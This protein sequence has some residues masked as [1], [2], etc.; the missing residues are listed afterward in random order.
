MKKILIVLSLMLVSLMSFSQPKVSYTE[1]ELGKYRWGSFT[2]T[3]R[4]V[5]FDFDSLKQ[6]DTL[7]YITFQAAG[8]QYIKVFGTITL[9][10]SNEVNE[11]DSVMNLVFD[12]KYKDIEQTYILKGGGKIQR[13]KGFCVV[14]AVFWDGSKNC[15]V[16]KSL[17][18][19][20]IKDLTGKTIQ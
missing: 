2:V 16:E 20:I 14:S 6:Y 9:H 11:F 8:Y 4:N 7:Y 19:K 1:Q 3:Q 15:G 12:Q 18:K 5:V 13:T 10:G 17:Y